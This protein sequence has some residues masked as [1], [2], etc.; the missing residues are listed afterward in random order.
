MLT[1]IV[2]AL[3]VGRQPPRITVIN[4]T[5]EPLNDVRVEFPGG[6]VGGG[7]VPDGD[8]AS[9]LLRPAPENPQRPGG[10][11]TLTYRV[12]N[13]PPSRFHSR[14]HGQEYGAH[15]IINVA[16]QP[17]GKTIAIPGPEGGGGVGFRDLLKRIGIGR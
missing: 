4:R 14:V 9:F 8:K 17:D 1:M 6:S 12:G 3:V 15:D 2:Y 10:P 7:S 5:G 13:D 11:I 16:R